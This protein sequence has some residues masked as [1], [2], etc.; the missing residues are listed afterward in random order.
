[1]NAHRNRDSHSEHARNARHLQRRFT[2]A[3]ALMPP[4]SNAA[5]GVGERSRQEEEL[6]P[7]PRRLR[8][9]RALRTQRTLQA[10][11]FATGYFVWTIQP[12][13]SIG[14]VT[15]WRAFTG[16][17]LQAMTRYGWLNAIHPDERA[18]SSQIW[19]DA[20]TRAM[21]FDLQCRVRRADHEYRH[22][23][24][25]GVPLCNADGAM[26]EWVLTGTDITEQAA[27]GKPCDTPQMQ[28]CQLEAILEAMPDGV[29]VFDREGRILRENPVAKELLSPDSRR[30]G[31]PRTISEVGR[32]LNPR[33]ERG[34]PLP[35]EQWPPFRAL[36]GETLRGASAIDVRLSTPDGHE[37]LIN[38]SGAPVRDANGQIM[39]A[40][41]ILRD[42]SER[43]RLER[44]TREAL[45]ALVAMAE[46]LVASGAA[47]SEASQGDRP[48]ADAFPKASGVSAGAVARR[49]ADMTR[50]VTGSRRVGII[51]VDPR[52]EYGSHLVAQSGMT[53]QE[54]EECSRIESAW[55]EISVISPPDQLPLG[56]VARL[57]RGESI[58]VDFS[59]PEFAGLPTP[60]GARSALFTPMR[61]GGRLVGFLVLD[62]DQGAE[63]FMPDQL[64]LLEGTARLAALVLE[65]DGLSRERE[66]A[67]SRELAAR[68]V[69]QHMDQFF[70]MAAHEIRSPVTA[71][72]GYAQLALRLYERLEDAAGAVGEMGGLAQQFAAL[73]D[74]LLVLDHNGE[75]LAHL[76]A[77]LFDVAQARTGMFSLTLA[78]CDMVELLREQVAA[79]CVAA[80]ARTIRLELL[81]VDTVPVLADADRLNQVLANYLT[82]A[83]KYSA[84]DRLVVVRLEVLD[85][86]ARVSVL[87]QGPGLSAEEQERV[88]EIFHRAPGIEVRNGESGSLG[89]GLY[90]CKTIIERHGGTVGVTSAVGQGST[91]WFTVPL[92]QT[93][94]LATS[95]D[96]SSDAR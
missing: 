79:Q 35:E 41:V 45:D 77:R 18:R 83:L 55:P 92:A 72:Q 86:Q 53:K 62:H 64:A 54:E 91:F 84:E 68:Q 69:Q 50:L 20:L 95:P 37:R 7:T 48:S 43:W 65:R 66:E 14:D 94:A 90:I 74:S 34:H 32:T 76:V 10:D 2:T 88:W 59:Q 27:E 75:R 25:R 81:N 47:V 4:E 8:T 40:V 85:Q 5:A 96:T 21:P 6:L 26:R 13:G 28:A 29:V 36:R 58:V 78:P 61:L 15:M 38:E 17:S 16:E 56:L 19:A 82:N 89:L 93:D 80:P 51:A 11:V 67:H 71:V 23:M 57:T 12:D 1:M 24:V 63:T 87:D 70:A 22:V 33:D 30:E 46:D 42:V 49:L 60:F 31:L 39:G 73:R 3:G 44:Q 52:D 9:R